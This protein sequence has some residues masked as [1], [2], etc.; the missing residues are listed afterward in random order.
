MDG[1]DIVQAEHI[2]RCKNI[3][4]NHWNIILIKLQFTHS[5]FCCAMGVERGV[6]LLHFFP[7][8]WSEFIFCHTKVAMYQ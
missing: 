4:Q 5:S 8:K 1:Y 3:N 7:E 2:E 6:K